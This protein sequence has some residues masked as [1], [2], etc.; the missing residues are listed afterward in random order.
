VNKPKEYKQKPTESDYEKIDCGL[1]SELGTT[2]IRWVR[3]AQITKGF[4]VS[5]LLYKFYSLLFHSGWRTVQ[6]VAHFLSRQVDTL[7][8]GK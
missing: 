3:Y 4:F 7:S 6:Q 2:E 1:P 5:F 8:K